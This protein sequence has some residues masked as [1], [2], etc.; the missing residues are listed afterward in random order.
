FRSGEGPRRLET[1]R[2]RLHSTQT[3]ACKARKPR[4]SLHPLPHLSRR[5]C[6]FCSSCSSSCFFVLLLRLSGLAGGPS[7]PC[8]LRASSSLLH[9]PRH[10]RP[11]SERRAALRSA[12]PA[13]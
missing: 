5:P 4:S 1:E 10:A 13:I 2:F 12:A 9:S 3:R 6:P 8:P 7:D 11:K